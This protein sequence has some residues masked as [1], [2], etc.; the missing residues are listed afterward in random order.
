MTDTPG[1]SNDRQMPVEPEF[2]GR[3]LLLWSEGRTCVGSGTTAPC[4]NRDRLF[5][6]NADE[7]AVFGRAIHIRSFVDARRRAGWPDRRQADFAILV[8]AKSLEGIGLGLY[9]PNGPS[10]RIA[11]SQ[12]PRRP[13]LTAEGDHCNPSQRRAATNGD[14]ECESDSRIR[15]PA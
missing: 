7:R 2:D 4:Q 6:G 8:R 11:A 5:N 12:T 1:E 10:V 13:V 15:Q 9:S 14:R 3:V